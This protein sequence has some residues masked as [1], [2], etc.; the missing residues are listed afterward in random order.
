MCYLLIARD[1]PSPFFSR[2]ILLSRLSDAGKVSASQPLPSPSLGSIDTDLHGAVSGKDQ[3]GEGLLGAGGEGTGGV[4]GGRGGEMWGA[5][6]AS[7][8]TQPWN[9]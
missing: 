9:I 2:L 8:N 6:S 5:G 1:F 3:P 7:G 4:G